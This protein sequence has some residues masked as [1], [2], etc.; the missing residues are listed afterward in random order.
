MAKKKTEPEVIEKI[1]EIEKPHPVQ[2]G[3]AVVGVGAI[4]MLLGYLILSGAGWIADRNDDHR[5]IVELE[6]LSQS[7][8][9]STSWCHVVSNATGNSYIEVCP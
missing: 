5:R 9:S 4:V 7:S 2:E 6:H 8:A 3:L 1:I